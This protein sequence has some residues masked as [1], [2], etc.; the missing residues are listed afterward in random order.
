MEAFIVF[1]HQL[2]EDSAG[3]MPAKRAYLIEDPLFF[4][5]YAFHQ[6]KLVLH[7]ATLRMHAA[8]LRQAGVT[9][10][11][12][13]CL[14]A[15][16][17]A[18]I[19]GAIAADGVTDLH[20]YDPC[21]DWLERRL[22]RRAGEQ[23]I[24]LAR[25]ES[26]MFLTPPARL[27]AHFSDR[28][29]VTMA[30]FYAAQ[31]IALDVL[32]EGGKP[33]GGRWSFDTE[34][35]RRLPRGE[36]VPLVSRPEPDDFVREAVIYVETKFPDGPGQARDFAYP[37]TYRA[38]RAWLEEFVDQRLPTFGDFEDAI[39]REHGILYHSVLTPMLNIGLLT[40]DQVL[41]SALAQSHRVP[42]NSLE[43]FVRQVIGWREYIHGAYVYRGRAQRTQNFFG[44]HQ[45]L[46]TRFWTA[47]TG[48]EPIDTV[49][50]RVLRHGYAHHIERLM[51]LSSFMLLCEIDPH[52]VYRFFMELFVDAYDWVMV[53][54]VYGM[55]QYADGGG[56]MTKPYLCGS[57][58]ILKMSD[59]KKGPWCEIWDALYWRF[60][61]KHRERLSANPRLA[62]VTR[63]LGRMD[64][65][66]LAAHVR[67]AE[68]F[69]LTLA[70]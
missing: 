33:A 61:I 49:L 44:H 38:A 12:V 14:H 9:V 10:H 47:D 50:R 70:T 56:I 37:V 4:S 2:F 27:Q 52:D 21:D 30:P 8:H 51:V 55:G 68:Q 58:Y 64:A 6:Q 11:Y 31:R 46:P 24:Q 32:V 67:T 65:G 45:R 13:D 5:M 35:R 18:H 59:F 20:Y 42:L 63:G 66:K 17:M 1:P 25:H 40:P 39:A 53:P 23:G 28:R 54:N 16:S 48:I 26:P 43:G 19:I 69:L 41:R 34:N 57:N 15:Q 3:R 36:P 29:H 60:L 7:R 62:V 22:V